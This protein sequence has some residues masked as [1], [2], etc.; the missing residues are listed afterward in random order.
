MTREV[1]ARPKTPLHDVYAREIGA[2]G[3]EIA[4]EL[5][6]QKR[7]EHGAVH[8]MYTI[9]INIEIPVLNIASNRRVSL[10]SCR[11]LFLFLNTFYFPSLGSH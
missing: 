10:R 7:Y 5:V 2:S 4:H 9:I 8:N 3:S 1:V 6:R 11:F